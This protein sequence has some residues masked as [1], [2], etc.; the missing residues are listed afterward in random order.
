MELKDDPE[1]SDLEASN[2]WWDN[3]CCRNIS[4]IKDLF[5]GQLRS[6]VVCQTC[7]SVSIAYDPFWDLSVSIP[8]RHQAR[9]SGDGMS[10]G[11][12]AGTSSRRRSSPKGGGRRKVKGKCSLYECL[13]QLTESEEL[14]GDDAYYCSKCKQHQTSLKRMCIFRVPKVLV[15]HLKRFSCVILLWHFGD[16][17][18]QPS[19][20]PPPSV[21]SD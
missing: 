18:P 20:F 19:P 3:Y 8:K 11:G 9:G 1:Q 21:S 10:P 2:R 13:S 4:C 6:E 16:G 15:L 17:L 5:C 14:S 7:K 12:A